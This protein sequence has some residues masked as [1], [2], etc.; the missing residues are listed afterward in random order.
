MSQFS[1]LEVISAKEA[2]IR[3]RLESAR[4]R[5]G[6]RKKAALARAEQRL[7]QARL[8][9]QA[10][11]RAHYQHGLAEAEQTA[12]AIIATAHTEAALLRRRAGT[13]LD[14]AARRLVELIVNHDR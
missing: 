9:G 11:A 10:A 7:V 6:A 12:A 8:E 4:A 5:A 14:E 13:R 1:P 2:E 3:Q